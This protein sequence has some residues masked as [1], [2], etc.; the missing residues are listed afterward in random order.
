MFNVFC[1]VLYTFHIFSCKEGVHCSL[2]GKGGDVLQ[3]LVNVPFSWV[4]L[5]SYCEVAL[6]KVLHTISEFYT[7]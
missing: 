3:D 5:I 4:W 7:A 1:F 2:G 6:N